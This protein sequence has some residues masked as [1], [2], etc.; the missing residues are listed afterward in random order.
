MV[1]APYPPGAD[2][3]IC[4]VVD[5]DG[6]EVEAVPLLLIDVPKLEGTLLLNDVDPGAF[7]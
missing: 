1:A 2:V 4:E 5:D 3:F 7:P 6:F